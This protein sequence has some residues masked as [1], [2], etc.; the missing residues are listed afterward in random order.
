[1]TIGWCTP[2]RTSLDLNILLKDERTLFSLSDCFQSFHWWF[3]LNRLS[4]NPDKS[5]AIIIGTTLN[6]DLRVLVIWL[7]SAMF[8]SNCHILERVIPSTSP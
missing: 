7:I 2:L 5:K 8:I 3:I 6:S 4:L 1:M